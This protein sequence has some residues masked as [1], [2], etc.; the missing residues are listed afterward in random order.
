MLS[1]NS[2]HYLLPLFTLHYIYL[3]DGFIQSNL[4]YCIQPSGD[5][6]KVES[7]KYKFMVLQM[8]H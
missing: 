4:Q 8:L 6:Q 1:V 5:K 3:V 7:C 2:E